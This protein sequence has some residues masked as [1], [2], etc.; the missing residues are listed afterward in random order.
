MCG[1]CDV[2]SALTIVSEW[3][4]RRKKS[5]ISEAISYIITYTSPLYLPP[6]HL[7][8]S[9][10]IHH[11]IYIYYI[12]CLHQKWWALEPIEYTIIN[13]LCTCEIAHKWPNV[14]RRRARCSVEN[15]WWCRAVYISIYASP[16]RRHTA[17]EWNKWAE[18]YPALC[19]CV[20]WR[21]ETCNRHTDHALADS[22]VITTGRHSRAATHTHSSRTVWSD[23]VQ[24]GTLE[25]ADLPQINM[26]FGTCRKHTIYITF[27]EHILSYFICSAY[28]TKMALCNDGMFGVDGG[29]GAA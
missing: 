7:S 13:N 26:H 23:E 22:L 20:K 3:N 9:Q 11:R 28:A 27:V 12:F 18:R 15:I 25:H 1:S 8:L 21:R 24:Y 10:I 2:I 6:I 16:A 5:M 14:R 17:C 4:N 19:V 29:P